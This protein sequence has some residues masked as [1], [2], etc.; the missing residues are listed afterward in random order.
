M[1]VESFHNPQTTSNIGLPF[2]L[3]VFFKSSNQIGLF[4]IKF[5]IDYESSKAKSNRKN[6]IV[7]H[8]W[9]SIVLIILNATVTATGTLILYFVIAQNIK[10]LQSEYPFIKYNQILTEHPAMYNPTPK[11]TPRPTP[12]L[13][14]I[15]F[16]H[17]IQHYQHLYQ[18]SIL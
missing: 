12:V 7:K 14:I 8:R 13:I 16:Q 2:P 3:N 18:L 5:I 4:V 11:P 10:Q 6:K 15:H 1:E 9:L 17:I